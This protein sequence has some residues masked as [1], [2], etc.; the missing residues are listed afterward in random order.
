MMRYDEGARARASYGVVFL[1]TQKLLAM[2]MAMKVRRQK[3]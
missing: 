2:A 1:Q 3:T